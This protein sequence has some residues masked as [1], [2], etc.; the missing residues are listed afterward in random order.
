MHTFSVSAFPAL[1]FPSIEKFPSVGATGSVPRTYPRVP[2]LTLGV[3][4]LTLG[5][6]TLTLGVPVLTLGVSELGVG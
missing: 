5:V 4:A 2:A 3:P 1:D 6:S